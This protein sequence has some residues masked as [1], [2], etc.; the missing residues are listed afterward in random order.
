MGK[1]PHS[2]TVRPADSLIES[3]IHRVGKEPH[4]STVRL[5]D[6]LIEL[7]ANK[8]STKIIYENFR[9]KTRYT[10]FLKS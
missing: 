6:S 5:A 7:L 3:F 1:E 9:D 10:P 2:S 4:S 8:K